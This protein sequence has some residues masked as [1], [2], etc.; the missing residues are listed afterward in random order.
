MTAWRPRRSP[1]TQSGT[2]SRR[3]GS[4]A[5]RSPTTC[6]RG[7]CRGSAGAGRGPG[8][9]QLVRDRLLFVRRVREA[10]EAG[11]VPAV[12]LNEIREIFERV[13]PALVAG[14]ADGRIAVT[15]ELVGEASTALRMPEMR[16]PGQRQMALIPASHATS[17]AV[18][19]PGCACNGEQQASETDAPASANPPAFRTRKEAPVPLPPRTPPPPFTRAIGSSP[20]PATSSPGEPFGF[21]PARH[22]LGRISRTAGW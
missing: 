16:R 20:D 21:T 6:R 10:E 13:S 8:I 7:C 3:P 17:L 14:V 19:L 5:A 2:W 11:R 18:V 1:A 4:T 9:P 22:H 15:P 12:S